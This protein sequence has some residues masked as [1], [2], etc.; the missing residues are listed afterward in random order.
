MIMHFLLLTVLAVVNLSILV[1][2]NEEKAVKLD[3][4]WINEQLPDK[5]K[6]STLPQ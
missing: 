2:I 6:V 1:F 5:N 3:Q 4:L